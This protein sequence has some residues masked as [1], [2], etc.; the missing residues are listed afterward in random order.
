MITFVCISFQGTTPITGS[1]L[2]SMQVASI[3]WQA[4]DHTG[5]IVE[6]K[7][8]NENEKVPHFCSPLLK[9]RARALDL[10]T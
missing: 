2:Q 5:G 10:T 6:W 1:G 4:D 8:K 9:A 3:E 7:G